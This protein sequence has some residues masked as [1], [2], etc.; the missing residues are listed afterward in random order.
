M[1]NLTYIG[2]NRKY[3]VNFRIVSEHIVE[4][5]GDFPILDY[6]FILTRI[7]DSNAFT[8]DYSLYGTVYRLLENG[9]QFSDDG[10][11]YIP[12]EP[13]PTPIVPVPV[14]P[15]LEEIKA[16]KILEIE[17][18]KDQSIMEGVEYKDMIFTYSTSEQFTIKKKLEQSIQTESSVSISGVSLNPEE[19]KEL[20]TMLENNEVYHTLYAEQLTKF[21]NDLEVKE[22]IQ[23]VEYGQELWGEYLEQFNS[24]YEEEVSVIESFVAQLHYANVESVT[25]LKTDMD[26]LNEIF[27]G[28]K[29]Q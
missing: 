3:P 24:K 23:E 15:T 28:G 4:V 27:G 8:G 16:T 1:L 21:V 22:L 13:K 25:E 9:A 7:G 6:G 18:M 14:E 2:Q 5:T 10:S 19:I 11:E 20:Y 17:S 29:K 26:N 12:P